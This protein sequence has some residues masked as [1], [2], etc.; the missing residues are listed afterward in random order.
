MRTRALGVGTTEVTAM[1]L[2]DLRRAAE[3][4][5]RAHLALERAVVAA[6]ASGCAPGDVFDAVGVRSE[7]DTGV[8]TARQL[9]E[10]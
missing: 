4:S 5:A 9:A 6:F 2:E 8:A 7:L 3:R 1:V 10:V